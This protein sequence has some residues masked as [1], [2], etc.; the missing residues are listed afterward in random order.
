MQKALRGLL[1]GVIIG[2]LLAGGVVGGYQDHLV[3][4]LLVGL[5]VAAVLALLVW[6]GTRLASR[7]RS[8]H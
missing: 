7:S 8:S 1:A 5:G 4:G 3:L 2:P 6:G